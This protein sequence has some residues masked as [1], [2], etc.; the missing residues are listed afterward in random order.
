MP[1]EIPKFFNAHFRNIPEN[2]SHIFDANLTHFLPEWEIYVSTEKIMEKLSELLAE[3][4]GGNT[5]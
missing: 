1:A 5:A 4:A 2:L 3:I